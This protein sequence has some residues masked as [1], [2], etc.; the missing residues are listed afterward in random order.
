MMAIPKH[1]LK[2]LKRQVWGYQKE[3]AKKAGVEPESVSRI[4]NGVW[5]NEK[6]LSAAIEVR[7]RII[8]EEK[9]K[10]QRL[11]HLASQI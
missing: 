11:K 2:E 1:K 3:I 8:A 10:S 5:V 9:E 4:L 7:D 6:V